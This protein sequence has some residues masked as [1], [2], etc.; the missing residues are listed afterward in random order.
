[1]LT[2]DSTALTASFDSLFAQLDRWKTVELQAGRYAPM[3]LG[4]TDPSQGQFPVIIATGDVVMA[5]GSGAGVLISF[6]DVTLGAGFQFSGLVIARRT[7]RFEDLGTRVVGMVVGS[8]V[9]LGSFRPESAP[10]AY[11]SCVLASVLGSFG[12]AKP[13]IH[14]G[15]MYAH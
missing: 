8:T 12:Q 10:V 9:D 13:L 2:I 7:V 5:G 15:W 4:P 1:V 14:R 6:G 3:N 11:S